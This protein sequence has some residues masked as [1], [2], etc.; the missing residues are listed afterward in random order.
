M[1]VNVLSWNLRQTQDGER[2]ISQ[3]WVDTEKGEAV[4]YVQKI[5]NEVYKFDFQNIT[6]ILQ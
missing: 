5:D 4:L 3:V 2:T 6:R 1:V